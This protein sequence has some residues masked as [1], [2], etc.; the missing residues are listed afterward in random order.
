MGQSAGRPFLPLRI[1]LCGA[2]S[3][4]KSTDSVADFH[5]ASLRASWSQGHQNN[6]WKVPNTT[7]RRDHDF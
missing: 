4:R 3:S 1:F 5:A 7:L 6:A 2:G